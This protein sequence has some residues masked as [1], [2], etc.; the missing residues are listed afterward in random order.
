MAWRKDLAM[1][2][3]ALFHFVAC[4]TTLFG[5]YYDIEVLG[6]RV[7][8]NLKEKPPIYLKGRLLFLTV[9]NLVSFIF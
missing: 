8:E 6:W 5:M 1:S 4:V 3:K 9:W 7:F 2:L